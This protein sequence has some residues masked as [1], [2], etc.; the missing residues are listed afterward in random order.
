MFRKSEVGAAALV[1]VTA[2]LVAP[3]EAETALAPAGVLA[4]LAGFRAPT[5]ADAIVRGSKAGALGGVAFVAA[6]GIGIALQLVPIVGAFAVDYVLFTGFAMAIMLVP[7]YGIEGM[8][9]GPL[10]RWATEKAERFEILP[11]DDA[12]Q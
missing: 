10:V 9:A 6:T 12:R 11:V 4:G 1:C 7:L 8:V 2:L 5:A 3:M